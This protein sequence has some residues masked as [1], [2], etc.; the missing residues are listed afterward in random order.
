M[1][2]CVRCACNGPI[3]RD[4]GSNIGVSRSHVKAPRGLGRTLAALGAK[5]IRAVLGFCLVQI[6]SVKYS[7]VV[8]VLRS[9]SGS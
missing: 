6:G 1:V 9:G 2:A 5:S 3:F 8:L 4:E 7:S